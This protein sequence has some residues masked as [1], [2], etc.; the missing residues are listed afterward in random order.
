[1]ASHRCDIHSLHIYLRKTFKF[2]KPN[3]IL[4]KLGLTVKKIYRTGDVL[5]IQ[6]DTFRARR[7][8]GIYKDKY[9]RDS[10]GRIFTLQDIEEL[11]R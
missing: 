5:N 8:C 3:P 6:P 1:M 9:E 7:R 11:K 4:N 10:V 2:I